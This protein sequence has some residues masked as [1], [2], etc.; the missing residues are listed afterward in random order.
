MDAEITR[1]AG[2]DVGFTARCL[3]RRSCWA[4]LATQ[5]GGQPFAT[6]VTHVLAP[7]G[8]I[9]MLLSAMAEHSRHLTAEPRCAVMV[10][11]QP[12]NLN[13]QTA[14]RLTVTGRATRIEDPAARAYWVARHP[15]ARLYADFSDFSVW[16][17][18][19]E[20]GLF[21]AGFGQINRLEASRLTCPEAAVAALAAAERTLLAEG[22][23]PHSNS[24]NRLAH[25]DGRSGRWTMLGVDPDGFDLVQDETVLRIALPAPVRDAEG[26]RSA[27]RRLLG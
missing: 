14:P 15:Y 22:N 19:P 9:L 26:F 17:V 27:L 25:A 13:W 16:R 1:N 5:S 18:V 6:L 2:V 24:L 7:D 12:E 8:A 11:G 20:S 3:L 4:S 23:G 10:T 21:I